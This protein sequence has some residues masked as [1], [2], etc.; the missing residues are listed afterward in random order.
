MH[1]AHHANWTGAKGTHLKN[2]RTA[3]APVAHAQPF[4]G[5]APFS[6]KYLPLNFQKLA[7]EVQG[8][9]RWPLY[10]QSMP[11]LSLIRRVAQWW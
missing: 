3:H 1:F 7:E 11:F 8:P 5:K 6:G 4:H 10:C 9:P 2:K